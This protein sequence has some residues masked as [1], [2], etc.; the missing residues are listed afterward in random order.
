MKYPLFN[1][2]KKTQKINTQKSKKNQYSK[3]EQCYD[4]K[5]MI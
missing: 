5:A 1:V 4:T 3:Q 2:N